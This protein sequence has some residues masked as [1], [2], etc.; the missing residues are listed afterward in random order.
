ML[1]ELGMEES[2]ELDS[3]EVH[4]AFG[5]VEALRVVAAC[6]ISREES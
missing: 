3:Q 1:V 6:L 2:E 4:F 5:C